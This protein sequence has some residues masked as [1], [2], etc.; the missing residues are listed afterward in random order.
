MDILL[1][2]LMPWYKDS[3]DFSLLEVNK[4]INNVSEVLI[5]LI[6]NIETQ[7]ALTKIQSTHER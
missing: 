1:E 2:E 7:E 3:Y 5:A 6:A 4:S